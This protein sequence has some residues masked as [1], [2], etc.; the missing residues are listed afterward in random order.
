MNNL[1][2]ESPPESRNRLSEDNVLTVSGD[3]DARKERTE[4][5]LPGGHLI[6]VPTRIL[7]NPSAAASSFDS[8]TQTELGRRDDKLIIPV[9]E[10]KLNVEKRTV[11]TGRVLLEKRVNAYQETLDLPLAIRTFDIERV[12]LNRPIEAPPPVRQ[13]GDTTVYPVI[14]EQLV[15]TTQLVLKEEVRITRRDAERR[16]NRT[17]T[18]HRETITVTRSSSQD[19]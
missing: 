13:E 10:E 8:L 9:V 12:T 11:T 15:L 3:L 16:D 4:L 5:V 17:V 7:L 2:L 1:D 18:L 14:E 19:E 6:H